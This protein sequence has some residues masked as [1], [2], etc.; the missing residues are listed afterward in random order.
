LGTS[1]HGAAGVAFDPISWTRRRDE[2]DRP[3][4][5]KCAGP[6]ADA[7][8]A[9]RLLRNHFLVAFGLE[10]SGVAPP[11]GLTRTQSGLVLSL[12]WIAGADLGAHRAMRCA[13]LGADSFPADEILDIAYRLAG[14]L[15]DIAEC[16]IVHCDLSPDHVVVGA[17]DGA[18]WLLN[19]GASRFVRGTAASET[20]AAVDPTEDLR[21]L[22]RLLCW[23]ASG[24]QVETPDGAVHSEASA[25]DAAAHLPESIGRIAAQ[26]LMSG[27]K[28]GYWHA[29][30][31]AGDILALRASG[32]F[33]ASSTR[34]APSDLI[35]STRRLGRSPDVEAL[36]SAFADA[37]SARPNRD[38][39]LAQRRSVL[40]LVEGGAGIGKTTLVS[41][42]C[43]AMR[44][45]GA[46]VD[47]GK[48]NQYG[49]SRPMS[50]LVHALDNV[51]GQI[52]DEDK[53]ARAVCALHIREALG[54]LAQVVVDVVPRLM[55]LLGP[56]PAPPR[57]PPEAGRARFELLLRRFV[58]ALAT[59]K[60]PL[61]LV[62]DDLQWADQRS[63]DL[64]CDLLRDSSI[65]HLL[66]VGVYRSEAITPGHPLIAVIENI[67][68]VSGEPRKIRIAPW[69]LA[70]VVQL[71][72]DVNIHADRQRTELA[73]ILNAITAGNPL[74]VMMAL[75]GAQDLGC[76]RFDSQA[77]NWRADVSSAGETL[78]NSTILSLV[79]AQIARLPP[80][81]CDM[82]A[83]C[84]LF[85]ASFDLE[86]VAAGTG[87]TIQQVLAL[88][89]PALAAGLLVVDDDTRPS[90]IAA[91]RARHD[92]VQQAAYLTIGAERSR[93]L[94]GE[95]GRAMLEA[96]TAADTLQEN[97]FEVV[98][99]FNKAFLQG[100]S[101]EER[102]ALIDLNVSAGRQARGTGAMDAAFR[103]YSDALKLVDESDWSRRPDV[104]F[105]ISLNA[106]EVAYLAAEF[107]EFDRLIEG[108]EALPVPLVDAARVQELNF[109]GL[110]ARNRMREALEVGQRTLALLGAPLAQLGDPRQWP[111]PPSLAELMVGQPSDAR[112][113]AILRTLG[114]LMAS[115]FFLAFDLFV[116][117]VLTM[118]EI[119]VRRP[120]ASEA[121]LSFVGYG[122]IL[123]ATGRPKDGF[124]AGQIA[125]ALSERLKGADICRVRMVYYGLVDHWSRPARESLQ[126][127]LDNIR[128]AL[129]CGEL[130]MFD[131]SAALYWTKA[132]AIE[133]L[134]NFEPVLVGQ[135]SFAEHFGRRYPNAQGR[136]WLQFVH[137][138]TGGTRHGLALTGDVFDAQS[139]LAQLE[140]TNTAASL[141][142]ARFLM[143][144][145][146]WHRGDVAAALEQCRLAQPHA[147][148]A[149][150]VLISVDHVMLW[151]LCEL[152]CYAALPEPEQARKLRWVDS[153]IA[154]LRAWAEAAPDNFAHKLALVEAERA[155]AI[156]DSDLA[157]HRF[158][159][160][161]ESASSTHFL[162]DCALI[163]ERAGAFY[164]RIGRTEAARELLAQA[165]ADYR[166]WGA[167]A[168]AEALE[169]RYA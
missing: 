83:I 116:R 26:L 98:E 34:G 19:F 25:R 169:A 22:G 146:N 152:E 53:E 94:H 97:A 50:A 124:A 30:A 81:C 78:A 54:A 115:A 32:N 140:G 5:E 45:S 118:F 106:A 35:L 127:L 33:K 144:V 130:E 28:D 52:L 167:T 69:R 2:G 133:P 129:L 62:L 150:A 51:V 17:D 117:V 119:A 99:Q 41:D 82:V 29:A 31:A 86:K 126:P 58:G 164:R 67:A 139:E 111:Q 148:A 1:L 145:L 12:P 75:R 156:G 72:D 68:A 149:A 166:A 64:M 163:R 105:E 15:A 134:A 49:D 131:Y 57:L 23:L 27:G 16:G 161:L 55:F 66:I 109:R 132:W 153:S 93:Q 96:Y 65:R 44:Q 168:I 48:F 87:Q 125:M 137:A 63:L 8:N 165:R 123:C 107:S 3:I 42:A 14:I 110:L 95:I 158:D 90:A 4:I 157:G 11:L 112:E 143:A 10:C 56:Q 89:W 47:F 108:L 92:I 70:D 138:L 6:A 88:L 40:A 128:D 39:R 21:A 13:E 59:R 101:D 36:L 46:C 160:A 84:T 77:G 142:V 103:H 80:A 100:L 151:C 154:R 38:G 61:V 162:H 159:R 71:L 155:V 113:D 141:F 74:G 120:F 147:L 104:M 20:G 73:D 91:L 37:T 18:L 60:R 76:L 9:R 85:G 24:R 7:A 122:L 136:M 79:G 102:S 43:R 114:W 135:A 121:P